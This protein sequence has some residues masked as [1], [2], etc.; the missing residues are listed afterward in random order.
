MKGL[1]ELEKD[2]FSINGYGYKAYKDLQGIYNIGKFKFS[3]D[4]VQGDPFAS[5]SRVRAIIDINKSEFPRN[6]FDKNYKRIAMQDY[7]T[8]LFDNNLRK[9]F[10]K[11]NSSGKSGAVYIARCPQEVLDRTSVIVTD[12]SIEVRF[13]AGLPAQGRRVLSSE[14]WKMINNII[15]PTV[16]Q[17]LF[18][19]N[20]NSNSLIDAINLAEDQT[21]IRE[22]MKKRNIIVFVA[23]GS[24][25]P[26]ETGVSQ[27]PL[28]SAIRFQSPQSL[29]VEFIT[30]NRGTIKGL[31][32]KKGISIVVGGGYHGKS[33]L[34]QAIER[35][36]YNHILGDGREFVL[37]DDSAF[38]IRAEDGRA[39]TN[40]DISMFINNLPNK[41]DT[42]KF[43]S[44]NASGSTSQAANVVEA[45]ESG[46]KVL[47]IDEDTS[48][49]NFMVRDDLMQQLVSKEKEPITPFIE[50]ALDLFEKEDISTIMVVGSSGDFFD[51]AHTVIQMDNYMCLDVTDRAKE[52]K[53]GEIIKRILEKRNNNE[54]KLDIEVNR[55][56]N[57]RFI[58]ATDRGIKVKTRDLDSIILNKDEIDV[59]YIEQLVDNS[60]L[61]LIGSMIKYASENIANNKLTIKEIVDELL[62]LSR[63]PDGML[64]LEGVR[65]GTGSLAAPRRQ[66]IAAAINRIR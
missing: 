64:K 31:G 65:N 10:S 29:E 18:Y 63:T 17:S 2:I 45:I 60:Q 8:R 13:Y 20:I 35:G 22:E 44:E 28:G 37:T 48:A 26:R 58:K 49:T 52:I 12:A 6:L 42:I 11:I 41:K 32:L 53:R 23:N 55:V 62:K 7:L 5:P 25:L 36:V 33:T 9:N 15:I 47:L 3:I 4:H 61:N 40:T 24:I 66:E 57:K 56:L 16:E 50:V 27:K 21:F 30:P 1:R 39:I 46:S 38:K 34:L 19:K 14:L 43:V 59:S 51:I 54:L